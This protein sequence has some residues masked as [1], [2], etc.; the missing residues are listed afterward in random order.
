MKL[1]YLGSVINPI[2]MDQIVLHSRIKPSHAPVYFQF[3]ALK[4]IKEYVEDMEVHG[5]PPIKT[6]PGGCLFSWGPRREELIK[7][8]HVTWLPAVNLQIIKHITI[9]IS[10]FFSVL[11]WL[12][13]NIGSRDKLLISYYIY[14]PYSIPSLVL[15]KLFRCRSV[16]IITDSIDYS[17]QGYGKNFMKNILL[18]LARQLTNRIRN[19]FDSYIFLTKPMLEVFQIGSKKSIIMEGFSDGD[20][21]KGLENIQKSKVRTIMYAGLL[22][23]DFGV[24]KLVE[25]FMKL[26]GDYCLWLFGA[27][28]CE[29]YLKKCERK[30]QRITFF[31]KVPRE[32]LLE[33]ECRAHLLISVKPSAMEHGRYAFPSKILEYMAS[34]TPVL[35]TRV[36]GIPEEYFHYIYPIEDESEEGILSAIRQILEKSDEELTKKGQLAKAYALENKSYLVQG[37]RMVQF[38]E[39]CINDSKKYN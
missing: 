15:C 6:F 21:F 25:A 5:I 7:G 35:S 29:A 24:V 26:K 13:R 12:L 17:Y 10:T 39:E 28:E 30:D 9:G 14:L 18:R 34:G 32:E 23:E 22:S 4:G 33:R 38:F 2:T 31:G 37:K 16:V 3:M 8:L 19:S 20:S 36:E 1:Y 11:G 27:G